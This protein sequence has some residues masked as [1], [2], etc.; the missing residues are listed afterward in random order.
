MLLAVDIGNTST[1][2]GIFKG[3]ELVSRF[4]TP[5]T[6]DHKLILENVGT[7]LAEVTAAIVCSV[8]PDASAAL[9]EF[10]S[11]KQIDAGLASND[12]DF[13][14]SINYTPLSSLGTDRLVNALAA[15]QKYQSPILV[16]SFGTATTIDVID[17]D[18]VFLG[19]MIS[20]GLKTAARAL[21][22]NTS[23]LPEVAISKPDTL[24]GT[25]TQSAI[26]SG[27]V[28]GHV[29]M[30]EGLVNRV[31]V[32]LGKKPSII[33]TGGYASL[34]K[35]MTNIIDCVDMDLT[36]RGLQILHSRVAQ[37]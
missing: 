16:C 36:L 33:A 7:R 2:F 32:E 24:I 3:E 15:A 14:L 10:F 17:E 12:L 29:G 22:L 25:S 28:F 18:G 23:Q 20:P 11:Q 27:I 37:M 6:T 8:V 4:S 21:S 30:F 13:G 1:K 19:G 26:L 31:V 5:T 34:M 35:E 9:L